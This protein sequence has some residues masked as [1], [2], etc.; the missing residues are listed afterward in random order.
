MEKQMARDGYIF[1][2]SPCCSF[3]THPRSFHRARYETHH[4]RGRRRFMTLPCIRQLYHKATTKS[5]PD[6]HMSFP[7]SELLLRCERVDLVDPVDHADHVDHVDLVDPVHT[8]QIN[9]L[10]NCVHGIALEDLSCLFDLEL[11]TI[12]KGV[13]NE[14]WYVQPWV[15]SFVSSRLTLNLIF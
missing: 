1:L 2:I 13:L 15:Q 4:Y 9:T 3:L 5:P 7:F 10:A 8:C 12:M 14:Y 11:L 6:D